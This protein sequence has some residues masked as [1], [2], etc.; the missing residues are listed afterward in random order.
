MSGKKESSSV[1]G[2]ASVDISSEKASNSGFNSSVN[3]GASIDSGHSITSTSN[4][5][6]TSSLSVTTAQKQKVPVLLSR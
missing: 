6:F 2:R 3:A 4:I 1:T 5:G